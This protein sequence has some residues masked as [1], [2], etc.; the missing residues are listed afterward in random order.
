MSI[1]VVFN[2]SHPQTLGPVIRQE[3]GTE[4][5][6]LG[7]DGWLISAN[8]TARE[9]SIRLGLLETEHGSAIVFKM[10]SYFGRATTEVWDWIKTKL[11]ASA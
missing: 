11:E 8:E 10:D 4:Y 5:L 6:E 2:A 3:Y 7:H 9:V 1:F